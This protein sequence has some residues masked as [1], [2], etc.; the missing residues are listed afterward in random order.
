LHA[1][2]PPEASPPALPRCLPPPL[3]TPRTMWQTHPVAHRRAR[4]HACARPWRRLAASGRKR[5]ALRAQR[6]R[7]YLWSAANSA[8]H[9]AACSVASRKEGAQHASTVTGHPRHVRGI[10]AIYQKSESWV[11]PWSRASCD[12]I[13]EMFTCLLCHCLLPSARLACV[14]S[15]GMHMRTGAGYR[16]NLGDKDHLSDLGCKLNGGGG[17]L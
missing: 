5:Q 11:K 1:P 17:P 8:Q 13:T 7:R 2:R 4:R 6:R 15:I 10:A 9:G 12:G 14:S 3:R 16:K